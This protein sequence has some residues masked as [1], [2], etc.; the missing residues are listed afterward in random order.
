MPIEDLS[1]LVVEDTLPMLGMICST[2]N[3]LGVKHVYRARNG[4]EGFDEYVEKNPDIII[5][6]W[7][8]EP[9]DGLE[10]IKRIRTDSKSNNKMVPIIMI[11]GYSALKRVQQARDYGVTEFL[12]KPFTANAIATRLNHIIDKPR[13]FVEAD[14]Y[15]GP[16]RRRKADPNYD[17]PLKRDSDFQFD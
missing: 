10:L 1:I 16:D 9:V 3:I 15:F 4:A 6:D 12:V 17:G 5:T 7:L 14:G 13:G 8:M 11:T 2:L